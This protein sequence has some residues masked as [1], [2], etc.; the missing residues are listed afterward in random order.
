MS[1]RTLALSA[2]LEQRIV[3]AEDTA[4]ARFGLARVDRH[5]TI[6]S[7][8]GRVDVRV[9]IFG[10]HTDRTPVVLLHGIGSAQVLAA[11]LLPF[12]PYRQVIAIDWPGHGL[13]GPCALAP[14]HDMRSHASSVIASVL[15]ALNLPSVDLVGHS[16]GAQ[17][18]L[19]AGLDLGARIRRLVLLGAPGAAFHGIRPLTAMKVLAVPRVGPALLS[20]PMSD[21]AFDRFN[22]LALGVGAFDRQPEDLLAALRLMG[23]RTTNATSLASYFRAMVRNG[24]VREGVALTERELGRVTQPVFHAWGEDDVFLHP[25][26]A[27]RSIVAMPNSHLL[28]VPAAGHAPW[29]QATQQVGEAV[30]RHLE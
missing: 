14:N 23:T 17:F 28:R 29:L 8:A 25:L 5:L 24:S 21:R 26:E 12:L 6:D 2:G 19:Y 13:S 4:Y 30:A 20:R 11:P 15:N 27:A 16:M 18:S 10:K 3:A 1:R 7:N 9:S 22:D